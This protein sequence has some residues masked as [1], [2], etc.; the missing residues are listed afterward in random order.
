MLDKGIYIWEGRNCFLS[1]AHTLEDIERIVQAIKESVNELRKGGFLPDLHPHENDLNKPFI[2]ETAI[3]GLK[4]STIM[5]T[6]DQKQLWF[7]SV[8]DSKESQSLHETV[9]LRFRGPLHVKEFN[10][11]VHRI[12]ERHEALRTFMGEDGETQII[13][14]AMTLSIPLHDISILSVEEQKHDIRAWMD[15]DRRPYSQ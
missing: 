8:S 15:K 1:T 6:P 3:I 12:V 11:A 2:P 7:A 5:L 10:E 14:P 9:L 13:A 4:E